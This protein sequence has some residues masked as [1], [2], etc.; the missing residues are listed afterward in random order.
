MSSSFFL[1]NFN[2]K[3]RFFF[4]VDFFMQT[5]GLATNLDP[6]IYHVIDKMVPSEDAD[7][8]SGGVLKTTSGACEVGGLSESLPI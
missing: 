4:F 7:L 8:Q 2:Q 6:L 3:K 1:R 5:G